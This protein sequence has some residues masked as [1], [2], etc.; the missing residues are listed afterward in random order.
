MDFS[1][2]DQ[3]QYIKG[4]SGVKS[5]K[6]LAIILAQESLRSKLKE[7]DLSE[8][9]KE[10]WVDRARCKRYVVLDEKDEIKMLEANLAHSRVR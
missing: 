6:V 7:M 5:A 9:C 8:Q 1:I 3:V 4:S 10:I 2:G